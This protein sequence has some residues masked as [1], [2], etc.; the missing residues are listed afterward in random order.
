MY[1]LPAM[2]IITLGV[3]G[4]NMSNGKSIL[5]AHLTPVFPGGQFLGSMGRLTYNVPLNFHL[6]QRDRK[7]IYNG[8]GDFCTS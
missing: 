8:I 4:G 6:K 7:N 2:L 5:S 1:Y 3:M